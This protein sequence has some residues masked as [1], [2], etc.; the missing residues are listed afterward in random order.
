[1]ASAQSGASTSISIPHR[2]MSC[3]R[4][5]QIG[6]WR[7]QATKLER[8]GRFGTCRKHN[9]C[10][11]DVCTGM[12]TT[13]YLVI[14]NPSYSIS[15]WLHPL[16]GVSEFLCCVCPLAAVRWHRLLRYAVYNLTPEAK[17]GKCC[18]QQVVKR[19]S[20]QS[21]VAV[22][23]RATCLQFTFTPQFSG[24]IDAQYAAHYKTACTGTLLSGQLIIV[25]QQAVAAC[26]FLP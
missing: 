8:R 5:Q 4:P 12:G 13:K 24:K 7:T 9:F 10:E 21:T 19:I 25:E 15:S 11:K 18:L 6:G 2:C 23:S 16:T 3:S 17:G 20:P 22:F 14:Q 1:M 26:C